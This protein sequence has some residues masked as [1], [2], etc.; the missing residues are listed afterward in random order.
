MCFVRAG[1]HRLNLHYVIRTEDRDEP[2]GSLLVITY[3]GDEISL[4]LG[5]GA[6]RV[7][8]RIDQLDQAGETGY[9]GPLITGAIDLS[10]PSPS[11]RP[12]RRKKRRG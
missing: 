9:T 2:P 7:R 12:T 1:K 6:D 5:D 3:P 11:S 10:S 8:L 4:L